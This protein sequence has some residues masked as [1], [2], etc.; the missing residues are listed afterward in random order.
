MIYSTSLRNLFLGRGILVP[1]GL[2]TNGASNVTIS[3]SVYEGSQPN[4][5]TILENWGSYNTS[6]LLHKTDV[7]YNQPNYNNVISGNY[8]TLAGLTTAQTAINTG[9]AD[10][11]IVWTSNQSEE[12]VRSSIIPSNNF[13]IGPVSNVYANGIVKFF[14]TYFESGNNYTLADSIITVSL[15]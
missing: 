11:V 8:M 7:E 15:V 14:D 2:T 1:M 4:A 3:F 13:I 5:N 6:Y 12:N 9:N 10:W